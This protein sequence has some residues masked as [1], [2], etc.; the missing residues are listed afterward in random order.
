MIKLHK[1]IAVGLT[2]VLLFAL[3]S[4]YWQM[5]QVEKATFKELQAVNELKTQQLNFWLD[6]RRA[7]GLVLAQNPIFHQLIK[8]SLTDSQKHQQLKDRLMLFLESKNYG[9]ITVHKPNGALIANVGEHFKHLPDLTT[10]KF[11]QAS[12]QYSSI[13]RVRSKNQ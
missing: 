13:F 5:N 4:F 8:D 11:K 9:Q 2:L 7:D 3:S 1:L 6:E 12:V 10:E